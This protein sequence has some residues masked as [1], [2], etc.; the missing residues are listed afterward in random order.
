MRR[1]QVHIPSYNNRWTNTVVLILA[2]IIGV[3]VGTVRGLDLPCAMTSIEA[4]GEDS[5]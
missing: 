5:E 1:L 2:S 4:P 3:D